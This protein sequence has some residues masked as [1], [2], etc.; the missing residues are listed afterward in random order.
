[1]GEDEGVTGSPET[2][3]AEIILCGDKICEINGEI[4]AALQIIC[5][6]CT[7]EEQ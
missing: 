6:I 1:L 2:L 3:Y 7:L 4:F 5:Y